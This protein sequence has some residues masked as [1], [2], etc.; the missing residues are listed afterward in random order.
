M[1]SIRYTTIA[2]EVLADE[3]DGARKLYVP[4]AHGSTA[5]LLDG[6]QTV[7]DTFDYW[8]YG[9][10]RSRTGATPTRFGFGGSLQYYTDSATR[11]LSDERSLNTALGHWLV[12]D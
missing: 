3:R 12:R 7:T 10:Q 6:S 11:L 4:D 1:H 9:E 2:G 8:P 5:A